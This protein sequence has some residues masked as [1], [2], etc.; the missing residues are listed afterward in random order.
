MATLTVAQALDLAM[1]QHRAGNLAQAEHIYRAILRVDPL[2]A[3]ALHLLG[4]IAYQSGHPD[5][6]RTYLTQALHLQ[7]DFPVA[8]NSLGVVFRSQGKLAE[9]GTC[10]QQALRLNPDYAEAHYNLGI[11]WQHQGKLAEAE[12]C[13]QYALRLQPAFVLAHNNLGNV[14][15]EQGKL[16]EAAACYQQALRL[17]PDCAMA[18]NNLGNVRKEQGQLAEALACYEQAITLEPDYADAHLNRALAWLLAGQYE[19]GWPEFEWRWRCPGYALAP[20][21]APRWQGQP[22]QGQTILLR[23]EQ[24][25]GDTLQFIRYAALVKQRGGRVLVECQQPLL[26]LLARCPGID[27]LVARGATPSE[28]VDVQAPLLS[29]PCLF[30]TTLATVPA[31]IPYLSADPCLVEHWRQ[32]LCPLPAFKIGIAWQGSLLYRSDRA[33]SIPLTAFAPLGRLKGVQLISLQKGLGTEQLRDVAD[34]LAILDLGSRLDETA[35]A[36]MDTA[37]VMHSLDLVLTCDTAL[38]HLAGA[39]GVPVWL[40]LPF[41]SDWRWL[42]HRDE[43]PWYPNVRLFRQREPGNWPEV[44]ERIAAEIRQLYL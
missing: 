15:Q 6:A 27:G 40:A 30:G 16:T 32:Q 4:L 21:A 37:A 24:G 10:Y 35:G 39:L 38:G 5:I 25:L 26:Q 14:L 3:E 2:Q 33:R 34:H 42:L 29:L 41:V 31:P 19:Q 12:A 44:F 11:V 43:S 22:L 13:Y 8:H 28:K 20:C 9:A 18:H 7:P 1:Q 36:F 23:A 17:Q